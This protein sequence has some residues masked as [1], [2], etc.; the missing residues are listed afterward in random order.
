MP[1][2]ESMFFHPLRVPSTTND[3][4]PICA[5]SKPARTK[6]R[7]QAPLKTAPRV[8]QL[9]PAYDPPVFRWTFGHAEWT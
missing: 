2:D 6:E 5:T 3:S 9:A 4:F 8:V 1:M 7:V